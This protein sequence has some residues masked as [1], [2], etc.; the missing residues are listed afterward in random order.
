MFSDSTAAMQLRHQSAPLV[1]IHPKDSCERLLSKQTLSEVAA[2]IENGGYNRVAVQMPDDWLPHAVALCSAIEASLASPAKIFVLADSTF[3][4]CCP[5]EVTAMHFGSDC[6]VHCGAACLSRGSRLPVFYIHSGFQE[7]RV[8]TPSVSGRCSDG[9]IGAAAMFVSAAANWRTQ[10]KEKDCG[11]Q[12]EPIEIVIVPA[13]G[14]SPL[15]ADEKA[16]LF[17][18]L[19]NKLGTSS[20]VLQTMVIITVARSSLGL[21]SE[22]DKQ[23]PIAEWNVNGVTFPRRLNGC[24][25]AA[26]CF[27]LLAPGLF[28]TARR[29]QPDTSTDPRTTDDAAAELG[30]SAYSLFPQLAQLH[31]VLAHNHLVFSAPVADADEAAFN[32]WQNVCRTVAVISDR[33]DTFLVDIAEK[34][35]TSKLVRNRIRQRSHNLEVIKAA[36][37]VGIIVASLAIAGYRET[38]FLLRDVVRRIAKKRCYVIYIGHIN[39]FKL[40]NFVDSV[41]C[42]CVI[43]C[44]NSRSAHF[45]SKSDNF[46]KPL[47]QPSEIAEALL[48][49]RSDASDSILLSD[50]EKALR[51]QALAACFTPDFTAV[52]PVLKQRLEVRT[53]ASDSGIDSCTEERDCVRG[54]LVAGGG[55]G[56]GALL[57]AGGGG[58]LLRLAERTYRGLE[59]QVGQ[60]PV[61]EAFVTGRAGIARGYETE[62]GPSS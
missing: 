37:S 35:T 43:A 46:M 54:E 17:D 26:Q 8:D 58:A 40:A 27:V 19:A 32:E 38:T 15:A 36:E 28:Q 14:T 50:E 29:S 20:E 42:F 21:A 6:I 51:E 9:M 62:K 53:D 41:D 25:V 18:K 13:P 10:Q 48:M 16:L 61:Q 59:P 5:D 3:G 7:S 31:L 24:G 60:T 23:P 56:G 2:F 1:G 45:P 34:S 33:S 57:S 22:T 47:V 39:E 30:V 12:L 55:R 49:Q 52:A 4:S 11:R 44:P